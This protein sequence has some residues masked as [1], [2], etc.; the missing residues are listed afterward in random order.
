MRLAGIEKMGYYPTPET[1]YELIA[2]WLVPASQEQPGRLLDP[3]AGK[4]EA[5]A[6]LGKALNCQTWG[7]ELSPVR[8]KEAAQVMDVVHAT[9]WQSCRL[10]D[11][12]ITVLFLN[13]PYD[14]ETLDGQKRLELEFLRSTTF[15]LV[16]GGILIYIVPQSLLGMTDVDRMLAGHYEDLRVFRFPAGE[17]ERF[18]QVVV[19]ARRK[20]YQT[21]T[22]KAI[23]AIR[24]LADADLAPL[25]MPDVPHYPVLPAPEKGANNRPVRFQRLDW[26]PEEMVEAAR[27]N[28]VHTTQDWTDLVQPSDGIVEMNPAMPLKKG[29][30]AMLMASGMMG[31]LRLTD[32]EG[33]PMLV[34]GRV[35][36]VV[37]KIEERDEDKGETV[38]RYKDR[39]VTTVG[40]LRNKGLEVISSVDELTE[41]MKVHG[42]KIA[43]HILNAYRP[44]Y[45]L[46]PLSQELAVVDRLGKQRKPLPGQAEPGLLP[47]QKHAAIALARA[48]RE[49]RTASL[50]GE[51]GLGKTTVAAAV[52]DLLD[53]YPAIVICP[54]HLVPKWIREVRE[55]IPGVHARELRR[56]GRNGDDEGDVNDV[57]RFLDDYD[58]GKLGHKAVVVV[59]STSAKF[60]PGWRPSVIPRKVGDQIVYTCPECGTV[61]CEKKD[62]MMVPVTDPT[63]FEKKRRFC[64]GEVEGWELDEDGRRKKDDDGNPVWGTRP[65]G[66]PLFEYTGKRRFGIAEYIKDHAKGR[67]KMLVADEAHQYKAKSSD[68]GV[69]FAQLVGAT[70]WTL[71][72]TGT[73]FGGKST[74]IFWL[75]HRLN[76]GVRHDF[77]FHEEKRWASLYGVLETIER[78]KDEDD[79][80]GVYTGH[81]RYRNQAKELPGISPAIVNRLL[82]N[83]LFLTLK[84]LGVSLPPY[85]E[86]MVVLEMT[87]EQDA[88][89]REMEQTLKKMAIQDKRYL[90]T[91]LQ[92]S[93]ARP[94]SAFRDETVMVN[95]VDE[96]DGETVRK[97]P[98]LDLP[99]VVGNGK[100]LPKEAWL[101][102]VCCT[103][104]ARGRKVLVYVRQT[105]TRDIQPRIKAAL[106]A[107]GLRVAVLHSGIGTRKRE[108][109]IKKRS[110]SIDVLITNPRL[111]ETGLDLVDFATVVFYEIEYSLYTLWQAMRRVWRLGQ[112]RPVKVVYAV[113]RGTMEEQAL[114][115]M[116]RK[117]KAAQLLYG[118]EVGGAIVPED[119][120][121]FLTEL[122]REVLRGAKLPDLKT[123]F[124]EEGEVTHS[125]VGCPTAISPRLIPAA[126]TPHQVT[127]EEMAKT[128][129][130]QR[131][132]HRRKVH[133]PAAQQRL[134]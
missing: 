13:P 77:G 130:V 34:K 131:Q 115:L 48:I 112:T 20:Q 79:E 76:S 63:Y 5:A 3:C 50:Q 46:V 116:G 70:K 49:H 19:F 1:V 128:V 111:V 68:R 129:G 73:Y 64:S 74:S 127:W 24:R 2:A 55:V 47:T 36:K 88:Q 32:E 11:E 29:H 26:L 39:F 94:N 53:A 12:S 90:S 121:D 17:Y 117:M 9:A 52:I 83:T 57:R 41:F 100:W 97:V 96:E 133:V 18:K 62:G 59:A 60:G 103:E 15:K 123:L 65:C 21:P 42:D 75:L 23:Q 110:H 56:I 126:A 45:E 44:R 4:G 102:H 66:A 95:V 85:S 114:A 58:A 105:A 27:Q 109:W 71:A 86:E 80:D 38:V 14:I 124:A 84:D 35:T 113:Y 89:Y 37:E 87:S 120:G 7:A 91:W 16:K 31:T 132:P 93:L 22:T 10:T 134:L 43:A 119:S 98:L 67:F 81:R 33:R 82:G 72:L 69:A 8:A 118:D 125:A 106:E 40:V 92:W 54:P 101:A 78:H 107:A 104:R 51:M 25:A 99:A 30:V 6:F 61:Q 108:A 122:A 28:G